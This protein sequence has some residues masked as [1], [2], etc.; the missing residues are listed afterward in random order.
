MIKNIFYAI[1][2]PQTQTIL[3]FCTTF[4]RNRKIECC[5]K[6]IGSDFNLV[7]DPLIDRYGSDSN[8]K[9]ASTIVDTYTEEAN[10]CDVWRIRNENTRQYSWFKYFPSPH[11]SR[12]DFFLIS[13]TLM[14]KVDSCKMT[15]GLKSDHSLVQFN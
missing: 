1:Y 11:F 4:Y 2:M 3:H 6:I 5:S 12:L 7:M 9:N 15:P 8:H 13:F 10:L 14:G